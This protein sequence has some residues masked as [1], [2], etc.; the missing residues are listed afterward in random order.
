M[1]LNVLGLST[2]LY[3]KRNETY[4][5]DKAHHYSWKKIKLT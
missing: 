4:F 1:A 2:V 5:P 3:L